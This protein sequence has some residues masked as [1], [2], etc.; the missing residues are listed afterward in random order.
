V[1]DRA[2]AQQFLG[3][4]LRELEIRIPMD[5]KKEALVE[6]FC[7]YVEDDCYE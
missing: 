6:A 5:I 2:V 1:L 7:Q 4:K 3:C